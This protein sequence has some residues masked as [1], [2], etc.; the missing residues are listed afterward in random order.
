MHHTHRPAPRLG[1]HDSDPASPSRGTP[2]AREKLDSQ[3]CECKSAAG[4]RKLSHNTRR[5]SDWQRC[6]SE[7]TAIR[8]DSCRPCGRCAE[9]LFHKAGRRSDRCVSLT[10]PRVRARPNPPR[11][12]LG[13]AQ[14]AA[15]E[16]GLRGRC[17]R[18][19]R[20]SAAGAGR[21]PRL[22][23]SSQPPGSAVVRS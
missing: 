9:R 16:A 18:I 1:G 17:E 12:P 10:N 20:G 19:C 21:R 5:P 4:S 6:C 8:S 13:D 23:L 11:Q 22:A 2:T 7:P 14:T 15:H 3:Q